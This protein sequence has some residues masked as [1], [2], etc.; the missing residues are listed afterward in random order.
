MND[1]DY[2]ILEGYYKK[3]IVKLARK[4]IDKTVYNT[5]SSLVKTTMQAMM[6]YAKGYVRIFTSFPRFIGLSL[7]SQYVELVDRFLRKS[8]GRLY[9][10]LTDFPECGFFKGYGNMDVFDCYRSQVSIKS[11][12]GR[13]LL[14]GEEVNF[15]VSDD[16]AYRLETNVVLRM[17]HANFN[18]PK[19]ALTLRRKFDE[20]FNSV[21]ATECNF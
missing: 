21:Y 3:D 15:E 19:T 1:V 16:R 12:Q 7:D 14:S 8:K 18:L 11:L 20:E 10:L 13:F 6:R 17:A 9:V 2:N 5:N 4:K